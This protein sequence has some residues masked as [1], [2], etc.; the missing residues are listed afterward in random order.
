MEVLPFFPQ[1]SIST[2]HRSTRITPCQRLRDFTPIRGDK[3]SLGQGKTAVRNTS[4][5][6][7]HGLWVRCQ[8]TSVQHPFS[9]NNLHATIS[10]TNPFCGTITT[11]RRDADRFSCPFDIEGFL[12]GQTAKDLDDRGVYFFTNS[13]HLPRR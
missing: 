11:R 8:L 3:K 6:T 2:S 9:Y 12:F 7:L 13:R 5:C 10:Q 1:R 4:C